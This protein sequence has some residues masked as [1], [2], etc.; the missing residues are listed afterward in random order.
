LERNSTLNVLEPN[1]SESPEEEDEDDR[2]RSFGEKLRATRDDEDDSGKSEDE[3]KLSLTE[4]EVITGEEDER[5]LHQVRSKLYSLEKGQ[6]KERGTGLLKLNVKRST[7]AGA[8]LVMRK[9]AV[10]ALLLN[11]TLFH[12]ML[13]ML[14]PQD[15]RYLRF[16]AIENGSTTH[17]NL[18]LGSAKAA[19]DL[20]DK[21]LDNIPPAP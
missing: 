16:S 2:Q 21:I 7:G 15:P 4:Q 19:Q 1:R 5:T 13:C 20:L 12:G 14:A 18:R 10:Y 11:V 9:E 8:R 17:Y 3:P 6:W